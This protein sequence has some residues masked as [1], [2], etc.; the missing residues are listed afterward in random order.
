MFRRTFWFT[1]G[2]AAGVWATTKVNRK[3]RQLTPESLAATAANKA[4]ETGARLKDRAVGFA[5][6]VRD[7]MAQREAELQDAL[8]IDEDPE[9]PAPR[10][11]A[12]IENSTHPRYVQT[13]T[14]SYDRNEDH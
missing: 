5:L 9:L 12:A 7:N 14:Y 10:R 1:T 6:D 11:F 13:T 8:G 2:V 3:L 4:L